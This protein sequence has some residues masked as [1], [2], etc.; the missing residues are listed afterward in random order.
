MSLFY[1]KKDEIVDSIC[2][3]CENGFGSKILF[4]NDCCIYS[5]FQPTENLWNK[6]EDIPS[7]FGYVFEEIVSELMEGV[8]Q[9]GIFRMLN[10]NALKVLS[11]EI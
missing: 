3:L 7:T 4:S 9:R 2:L 5:D 6:F 1:S 8:K 11:K 10:E